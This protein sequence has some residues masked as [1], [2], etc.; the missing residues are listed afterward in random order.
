MSKISLKTWLVSIISAIRVEKALTWRDVPRMSFE[1][2]PWRSCR[3]WTQWFRRESARTSRRR[4]WSAR[5]ATWPAGWRGR[6]RIQLRTSWHHASRSRTRL[7][8]KKENFPQFSHWHIIIG[9]VFNL[10][11]YA[12]PAIRSTRMWRGTQ[13]CC[14]R[15]RAT[16]EGGFCCYLDHVRA[17][18]LGSSSHFRSGTFPSIDDPFWHRVNSRTAKNHKE[19]NENFHSS[20]RSQICFV[21]MSNVGDLLVP[22]SCF[23]YV[24]NLFSS[25]KQ[26]AIEAA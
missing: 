15:P 16:C 26:A 21:A 11:N 13:I 25:G 7:R 10:C 19:T 4:R 3:F 2:R 17:S 22:S 23:L 6:C 12:E 9:S 24:N 20:S 8:R 5:T 1:R 14:N 18:L